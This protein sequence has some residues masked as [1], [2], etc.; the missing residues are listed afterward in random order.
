M[1][2]FPVNMPTEQYYWLLGV[3]FSKITFLPRRQEAFEYLEPRFTYMTDKDFVV[4]IKNILGVKGELYQAR[5]GSSKNRYGFGFYDSSYD[6][7]NFFLANGIVRFKEKREFPWVPNNMLSNFIRGYFDAQ[8]SISISKNRVIINF[9]N[10][11]FGSRFSNV[12][13]QNGIAKLSSAEEKSPR[14]LG[15]SLRPEKK[16]WISFRGVFR[17]N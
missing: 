7:S 17:F 9:C 12:L 3:C 14:P 16:T 13:M 8:S 4:F 15:L 10:L 2:I 5:Q 1:N 11:N 6:Y